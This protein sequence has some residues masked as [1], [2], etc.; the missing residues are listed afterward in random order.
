MRCTRRP[1]SHIL[2]AVSIACVFG[3]PLGVS[4][5]GDQSGARRSPAAARTTFEQLS[6]AAT[7]ARAAGQIDEAIALYRRAVA[8]RPAWDEGQWYL[9]SLLYERGR[10]A[11][12]RQAF[13]HV[14]RV[15]AGHAAAMAM[16]G[17]CE[18]QLG[19]HEVALRML[20]QARQLNIQR[21]P[22]IATVVRYHTGILLTRFGEFEAGNQVLVELA[23]EAPESP[24]AVEAFG[25][26]LLRMPLLPAEIP[27]D[28][29][30]RVELAG[31]AG[32]AMAA[33][34]A[35][36]ARELLERLVTEYGQTSHVHYAW[37]VFLLSEDPRRAMEAFRRE[38]AISPSHVPARLQIAFELVKQGDPAGA[39]PWAE[40][41]AT[42]DPQSYGPR[43][44]L[45]QAHLGLGDIAAAITELEQAVRL[46][47][48]S[49]QTHYVLAGAY[50]R[51][52]RTADAKR[53]RTA[54]TRLSAT[55]SSGSPA[56]ASPRP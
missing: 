40:Q 30:A 42:M 27:A 38:V 24:Q 29:R 51:A 12:A 20:L 33:R 5:A 9:G 44:A 7:T 26:N 53:E 43:L 6:A 23:V 4:L 32:Y 52:G 25:L 41:A 56:L 54:F 31:R 45:G 19:H 35:A 11:D 50:S 34:Q 8:L 3:A 36:Q 28:A 2:M 10:A 1:V 47:P 48:E 22:E 37:G 17:L 21:T 14:L 15:H 55:A 39:K 46:A 16:S 13:G 49:P 18:F